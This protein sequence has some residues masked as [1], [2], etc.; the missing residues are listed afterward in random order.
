MENPE[1]FVLYLHA[2]KTTFCTIFIFFFELFPTPYTVYRKFS[3]FY[4]GNNLFIKITEWIITNNSDL[5][6]IGDCFFKGA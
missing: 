1:L 4:F 6:L 5:S 3:V 2:L